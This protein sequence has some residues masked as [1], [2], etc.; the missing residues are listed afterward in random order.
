MAFRLHE[1]RKDYIQLSTQH[2]IKVVEFRS[3][4]EHCLIERFSS[5]TVA[6]RDFYND[7]EVWAHLD[8]AIEYWKQWL[9]DDKLTSAYQLQHQQLASQRLQDEYLALTVP[10]RDIGKYV[11]QRPPPLTTLQPST[12]LDS[13]QW[14]YLFLRVSRHTW[15]RKWVYL[16]AGQFGIAQV[17]TAKVTNEIRVPLSECEVEPRTD[18]ERRF[19]FDVKAKSWIYTLQAETEEAFED[20]LRAFERP[21]VQNAKKPLALVKSP[22]MM[23]QQR[24]NVEV[25]GSSL[26]LSRQESEKEGTSIVLVSTTPDAEAT[27]A[28]SASMTPLLIWEAVGQIP[29]AS[30]TWGLPWS[31]VPAM[32]METVPADPRPMQQIIWPPKKLFETEDAEALDDTMKKHNKELR[33]L[34]GGVKSDE[35]VLDVFVGCIRKKAQRNDVNV[36]A[37]SAYGYAYTG[38]GFITQYTFWFYSCILMTCINSAAICLR[39]I[40][41]VDVV[42]DPQGRIL[43]LRTKQNNEPLVFCTLME[44]LDVIARKLR[45]VIQWENQSTLP[46][47]SLYDD[48]KALS[49]Q[50]HQSVVI[51]IP[52]TFKG[53]LRSLSKK[54]RTATVTAATLV[55]RAI[56]VS[57]Q[58]GES[59][60]IKSL[61]VIKKAAPLPDRKKKKKRHKKGTDLPPSSIQCPEGPVSCDCADHLDRLECQLTLPISA[62]RL[63]E[64]M[65]SDEQKENSVWEQKTA[66]IEGHDLSVSKWAMTDGTLQRLLNY[67]MP[68][69]NPIVRMKEAEVVETQILIQKE[70]YIRYTVQISTKTAA[71]P[72]AE[73]FIPSVRYCITWVSLSECML[74]CYLGVRWTQKVLVRSIVTRAAMKGMATSVEVFIPILKHA[75]EEIKQTSLLSKA[76]N[77]LVLFLIVAVS[78]FVIY[79]TVTTFWR[80]HHDHPHMN[81]TTP[82]FEKVPRRS[83]YLRDLDEGF[84][85]NT[86]LPPY[87][88]T[89]SFKTFLE[90]SKYHDMAWYSMD[91]YRLA[92][93]IEQ[94]REQYGMLRHDLLT[95]FHIL[96]SLDSQLIESAYFNWM[97]DTRLKCKHRLPEQED[98][99][100]E[101]QRICQDIEEQLQH[102]T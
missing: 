76:L 27:L 34:F 64:L 17:E 72:Y 3:L 59:E 31:L 67:W 77:E 30:G 39:D 100:L 6:Q 1:A 78:V 83:V 49:S 43:L 75:A 74:S 42:D 89:E 63:Y 92:T 51:D 8:K 37:P 29:V 18:M 20:W 7:I 45:L 82:S 70:D 38:Y 19:C 54:K 57:R 90:A 16:H 69:A 84:L 71:L 44:D 53:A 22:T 60:P 4:L 62:K 99:L 65:F 12:A 36:Q 61:S 55:E 33:N 35:M 68:V 94:S 58:R 5:A 28:N 86:P 47:K 101:A 21:S 93:D 14:G 25:N 102:I 56:P 41:S 96:N 10:D 13:S 24:S 91:H 85:K 50:P 73:A 32:A 46:V 97:L 79:T 23:I 52:K 80:H 15:A 95:L 88:G 98:Q 48:L 9:L 2:V 66:A 11:R 26:T 81:V 87:A 40:V